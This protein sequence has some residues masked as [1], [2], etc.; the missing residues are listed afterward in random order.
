MMPTRSECPSG[1]MPTRIKMLI[2]QSKE[3]NV[4]NMYNVAYMNSD[5]LSFWLHENF[6]SSLNNLDFLCLYMVPPGKFTFFK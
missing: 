5:F 1:V 6:T 4:L 3:G 2:N